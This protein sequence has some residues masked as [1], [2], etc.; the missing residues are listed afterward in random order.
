MKRGACMDFDSIKYYYTWTVDYARIQNDFIDTMKSSSDPNYELHVLTD[1]NALV[2]IK[3]KSNGAKSSECK[4]SSATS[5]NSAKY[6]CV[7]LDSSNTFCKCPCYSRAQFDYCNNDFPLRSGGYPT[8]TP[9]IPPLKITVNIDKETVQSYDA[10]LKI[11]CLDK[12]TR[13]DCLHSGVCEWSD[14]E[15][16]LVACKVH[17]GVSDK[18][19]LIGWSVACV[20]LGIIIIIVCV[21]CKRKQKRNVAA[22]RETQW[23]N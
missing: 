12:E 15:M 6:Q 5:Y 17:T 18:R 23:Q 20:L 21:V 13:S 8:C 22:K 16:C 11:N 1:T 3:K 19:V 4:C 10:C 14:A 2:G 9:D 7:K